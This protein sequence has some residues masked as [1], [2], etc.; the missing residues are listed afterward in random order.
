[1]NRDGRTDLVVVDTPGAG[2][3]FVAGLASA[4]ARGVPFATAVRL[5][6]VVGAY[7]VTIRESIPAFPTLDQLTRFV[8][9]HK[10]EHDLDSLLV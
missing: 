2:D 8:R 6:N 10:L 7:A 5:G 4:L 9:S 3:A 1:M